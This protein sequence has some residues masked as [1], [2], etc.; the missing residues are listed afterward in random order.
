MMLHTMWYSSAIVVPPS[1]QTGPPAAAEGTQ[2]LAVPASPRGVS[3]DPLPLTL[4]LPHPA[5]AT[6][7]AP[8]CENIAPCMVFIYLQ[9]K[10]TRTYVLLGHVIHH[11]YFHYTRTV[12]SIVLFTC[13]AILHVVDRLQVHVH[14]DATILYTLVVVGGNFHEN[15]FATKLLLATSENI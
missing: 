11:F 9:P 15:V 13:L 10:P 7:T 14:S 4:P 2:L 3:G 12:T 8:H 1:P 5:V 6:A